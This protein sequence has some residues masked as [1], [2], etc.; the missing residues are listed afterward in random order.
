MTD[1]HTPDEPEGDLEGDEETPAEE[2]SSYD[3]SPPP[4]E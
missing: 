2:M 1:I 4:E 3:I